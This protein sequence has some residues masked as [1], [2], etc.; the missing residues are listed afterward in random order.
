MVEAHRRRQQHEQHDRLFRQARQIRQPEHTASFV[1]NYGFL[2]GRANL[3]LA[4]DYVGARD[5]VFFRAPA[6]PNEIVE[7]DGYALVNLAGSYRL[8]DNVTLFGRVENL[9]DEDYEEVFDF[10]TPGIG[11]FAGIRIEM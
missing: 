1:A 9:L 2:D 7:L 10:N 8:S 11:A 6:A 5:D 4:V 3:N